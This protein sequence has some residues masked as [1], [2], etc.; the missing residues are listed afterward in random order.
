MYGS[1]GVLV[2]LS[3]HLSTDN[4]EELRSLIQASRRN[5]VTARGSGTVPKIGTHFIASYQW[6]D[7]SASPSPH[8]FHSVHA[9]RARAECLRAPAIPTFF[10]LPWRMEASADLRNLWLRD[11]CRCHSRRTP[12][13]AGAN[14]AQF[15]GGL[16]FIFKRLLLR[17]PR[18]LPKAPFI[19]WHS[20]FFTIRTENKRKECCCPLRRFPPQRAAFPSKPPRPRPER[21]AP[22]RA[23]AAGLRKG[24][25]SAQFPPAP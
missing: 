20:R 2:P 23:A 4:P 11:I 16:S 8:V 14:A 5:A 17:L 12:P 15:R 24:P 19:P 7:Q 1:V 25:Q 6:M 9:L 22:T 21:G 13:A 3:D 18:K 10:S